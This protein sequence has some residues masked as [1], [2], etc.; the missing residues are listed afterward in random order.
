LV[1]WVAWLVGWVGWLVDSFETTTTAAAAE[2]RN[3]PAEC[4]ERLNKY[5][6]SFFDGFN[7]STVLCQKFKHV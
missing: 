7:N 5:R 3:G 4:A 1:V 6:I 2:P